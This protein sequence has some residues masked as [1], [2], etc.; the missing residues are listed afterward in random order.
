VARTENPIENNNEIPCLATKIV[1]G[2]TP[3][4][5]FDPR[6]AVARLPILGDS[7][8]FGGT[9]RSSGSLDK[10][11]RLVNC[12]PIV[13]TGSVTVMARDIGEAFRSHGFDVRDM[14][15]RPAE[16]APETLPDLMRWLAEAGDGGLLFDINGAIVTSKPAERFI[17]ARG[18]KFNSFT[19]LTDAPLHFPSRLENWPL[20]GMIG[21]VDTSFS[22]LARFMKYQR[23]EFIPF[24]HGG[25]EIHATVAGTIE[26]D[27]DVLF[28]GNIPVTRP[29]EA[30]AEQL[31]PGEPTLAALF[32]NSFEN[33][34]TAKTP[35]QIT[36]ET[37][38][39]MKKGYRRRDAALAA[40]HLERYLNYVARAKTLSRLGG[41]NVKLVGSVAEGAIEPNV[42]IH[43]LGFVP[44]DACLELMGR[45]K[46]VINI[47]PGLPNGAHERVFYALSRGAAV[48][49]T[50]STLL[51]A[52]RRAHDFID[53]FDVARGDIREKLITLR[54]KLDHDKIDRDAMRRHYLKH[55]TWRQRLEPLLMQVR[56]QVG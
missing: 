40:A 17:A 12:V 43:T 52:D 13:Q 33:R 51:E 2:F 44:F 48:L 14:C 46:I 37:A 4:L 10:T 20:G 11:M 55:H 5:F 22:E 21:L 18:D 19:F 23:P 6:D 32:V 34:D 49:T 35:F 1:P 27:I 8:S 15:Y 16:N 28:I 30:H 53:F 3:K 54:E 47:R 38:R 31:Y 39:S 24:P 9:Q 25:P 42:D 50:P 26:R 56:N 7:T 45:A 41:L 36:L 29:V